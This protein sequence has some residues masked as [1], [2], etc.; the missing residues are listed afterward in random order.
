MSRK[1][2]YIVENGV[3]EFMGKRDL[4]REIRQGDM[5]RWGWSARAVFK[6]A[7]LQLPGVAL[8]V[9]LLIMVRRWV[10]IPA[11][12]FWG[13]IALW[14]AKDVVLFPFVWRAY[15]WGR[16]EDANPMIGTRG[17]AKDDLSPSGHVTVRGEL[18]HAEV[19]G[20]AQPIDKGEVV[21]VRGVRGLTL[22]V[23]HENRGDRP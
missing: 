19:M 14:V 3:G 21:R 12:S 22:I 23:E 4:K 2:P 15:E 10:D 20:G 17:I 13:I 9:L 18:W 5:N 1:I 16:P 6:Y 8:I 7:L 11:W